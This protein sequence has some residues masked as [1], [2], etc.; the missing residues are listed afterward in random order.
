VHLGVAF[1]KEAYLKR[2][3]QRQKLFPSKHKLLATQVPDDRLEAAAV[4]ARYAPS[5]YHC[6]ENGRIRY[7]VKPATPCPR[8]FT[9]P[10]AGRALR[11]AIR[12]RRISEDWINDYPRRVWHREG[13]QWYVACTNVG[14]AGT[15]HAYPIERA[16][17][18][19]GLQK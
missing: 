9:L 11:E 7:R 12:A 17:L 18:P 6:P 13:D 15:Y 4:G 1:S 16:E 2:P 10:E 3:K 8:I 19:V 14:T 5:G